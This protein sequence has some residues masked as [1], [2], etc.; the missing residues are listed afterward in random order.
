MQP[1]TAQQSPSKKTDAAIRDRI[2]SE[3]R[4]QDWA[5]PF[6][7]DVIVRNGIVDLWGR[8]TDIAQRD[9]LRV[10]VEGTPGVKRAEAHLR[11][12]DAIASVT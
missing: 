11:W 10:M 7:I 1:S 5:Y 4:S 9:A 6:D 8:I 3:I 2:L 12:P